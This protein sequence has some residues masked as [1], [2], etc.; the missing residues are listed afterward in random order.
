MKKYIVYIL[1]GLLIITS[2]LFYNQFKNQK[3]L[4][5][6]VVGT[7]ASG[8]K[9]DVCLLEE[10]KNN[11]DIETL[12]ELREN[13]IAHNTL[14]ALRIHPHNK[15]IDYFWGISEFYQRII[16]N[17]IIEDEDYEKM[18]NV[19]VRFNNFYEDLFEM[20]HE[21]DVNIKTFKELDKLV[22]YHF[23]KG[24]IEDGLMEEY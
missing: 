11:P 12:T 7:F 6:R 20:E 1:I 18:K 23:D 3:E 22:L 2:L 21:T 4:E 14:L 10:L 13:I 8:I 9:D 19:Y 16:D 24:L 17:G 5:N 15:P